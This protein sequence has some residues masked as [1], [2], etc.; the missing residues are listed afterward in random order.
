[1]IRKLLTAAAISSLGLNPAAQAAQPLTVESP[2]GRNRI[3]IVLQDRITFSVMSDGEPVLCPTDIG[4]DLDNGERW[5]INPRLVKKRI[6]RVRKVEPAA[7]FSKD[8]ITDEYTALL[9]ELRGDYGVE[10]RVYDD[11][12]AYRFLAFARKEYRINA[13]YAAF[14]VPGDCEAWCAHVKIK[15]PVPIEKQFGNSFENN[16]THTVLSELDPERLIFTPSVIA[17]PSGKRLLLAESDLE[18]Y[19]GMFLRYDPEARM[20]RGVFAPLPADDEWDGRYGRRV[21]ATEN[22]I[23]RVCGPRT[24]PWRIMGLADSDKELLYSDIVYR[25]AAPSRVADT[26]WIRPGKVAWDWWND[27]GLTGVDFKAGANTLTYKYYIDFAAAHGLEYVILDE[28]WSNRKTRDLFD[29]TPGIDLPEILKY[30]ATKNIRIILWA[31]YDTLCDRT[32]DV[33]NHYARMG[34]AGFKVDFMDRDDQKMVRFIYNTAELAA[35]YRLVILYHGMYKPTGINRTYPH[36]LTFEGV[37]GAE[38][39]KWAAPEGYD[40][41]TYD[42]SIPF[43]RNLAGPMDYTPGGMRNVSLSEYRPN[44]KLPV[45]QGTRCHQLAMYV[46]FDSPI[47]MLCDSPSAYMKEP[48]SIRFIAGV[49]TVWDQTIA[50]E[51]SIGEYVAVARRKKDTWHVA[52]MA[53][54]TARDFTLDLSMIPEGEYQMEL[55][56]DGVNADKYATDYRRVE[57]RLPDERMLHV[58]MA[59][60][61]GFAAKIEKIK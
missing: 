4:M 52:G 7:F 31:G 34:V 21:V 10:F 53:G 43:L 33:F 40:E 11:A 9:L 27:W 38:Y 1:M 26:S 18:E 41:I 12:V 60:G 5:G 25:L 28:G 51:G 14:P 57:C 19:P 37:R 2:S 20:L 32:E 35:K 54:N 8:S 42:V 24:F 13:E 44:Y 16:Y 58:Q 3:E 59:A 36:V 48:E 47:S 17:L 15:E 50:L 61:G 39:F 29:P 55:F 46:V 49:P 45:V 22:C 30:A 56:T 6:S 23:A